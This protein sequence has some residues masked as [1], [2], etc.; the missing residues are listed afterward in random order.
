MSNAFEHFERIYERAWSQ[1]IG[2]THILESFNEHREENGEEKLKYNEVS[3]VTDMARFGIVLAVAAMDDYF[4]RKYAEVLVRSLKRH[5]VTPAFS[6]MLEDA[7]LDLAGALALLHMQKPYGR[8]RK[9]AQDY[10]SGHV[11]QSEN[12]IDSL[13]ETIGISN[14]CSH[15]QRRAKRKALLTSIR[16]L[17]KRRHKIVHAGDMSRTG[18]IAKIDNTLLKRIEHVELF[19]KSA[20]AHIEAFTKQKAKKR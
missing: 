18:V 1:V 6:K 12:R 19:V 14:L 10:Y 11:T 8:I 15:A 3:E 2:S 17:V 20:D 16:I 9:I 5:G 4:T 7:G 13:F